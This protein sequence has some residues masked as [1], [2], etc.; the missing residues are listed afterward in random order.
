MHL[1]AP[2]HC[3]DLRRRAL[4]DPPSPGRHRLQGSSDSVGDDVLASPPAHGDEQVSVGGGRRRSSSN[5]DELL[6]E[7][8]ETLVRK[9]V[10]RLINVLSTTINR[11]LKV[12]MPKLTTANPDTLM[13]AFVTLTAVHKKS[14]P[15][16]VAL[17]RSCPV[18]NPPCSEFTAITGFFA[19]FLRLATSVTQILQS[20]AA[21]ATDTAP[22]PSQAQSLYSLLS[23]Q[24][25]LARATREVFGAFED[26]GSKPA[27][28][29]RP[30]T[31]PESQQGLVQRLDLLTKSLSM[32]SMRV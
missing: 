23:A 14:E 9:K 10:L 6:D 26:T 11:L 16:V 29:A 5:S 13:P 19:A 18:F 15:I 7:E 8:T 1:E 28:A 4:S 2:A 21:A 17:L 3:Q 27:R 31:T 25:D 12:A 22:T 32:A 24:R 20:K 30:S